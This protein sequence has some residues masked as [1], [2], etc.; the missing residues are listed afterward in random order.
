MLTGVHDD[1]IHTRA[2]SGAVHG[3]KLGEVGTGADD[4]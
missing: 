4:V 3:R 2:A 1:L